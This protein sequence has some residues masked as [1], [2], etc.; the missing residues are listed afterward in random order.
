MVFYINL[1]SVPWRRTEIKYKKNEAFLDVIESINYTLS[2]SGQVIYADVSGQ[3]MAKTY[4]S[5]TPECKFGLN[6][7][8][9]IEN[10]S[11]AKMFDSS[12]YVVLDDCQVSFANTVSSL[13]QS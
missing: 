5:G 7:K 2:E 11:E 9:V 13:R 4:L 3:V 8:L 1:G 6:D 10:K 12:N